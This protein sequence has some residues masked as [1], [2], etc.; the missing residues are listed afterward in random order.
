M[1]LGSYNLVIY[2]QESSN[3][4]VD[5]YEFDDSIQQDCEVVETEIVGVDD[6]SLVT[7]DT[8]GYLGEQKQEPITDVTDD[9]SN[10][11]SIATTPTPRK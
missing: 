10:H 11:T 3:A 8:L 5:V 9:S 4:A 6:D 1:S 7:W 2:I